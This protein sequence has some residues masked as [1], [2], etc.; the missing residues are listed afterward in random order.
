METL[1]ALMAASQH[2]HYYRYCLSHA[3]DVPDEKNFTTTIDMQYLTG[4][5]MQVFSFA[6]VTVAL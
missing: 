6:S 3:D 1:A 4:A 2:C 5:N